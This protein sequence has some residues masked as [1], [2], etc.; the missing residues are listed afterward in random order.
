MER[1]N[2]GKYIA[3]RIFLMVPIVLGVATLSFV[4]MQLAPGDPAAAY[5]G[6]KAT[7]EAVA[8]LY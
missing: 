5:L 1:A 3:R 4:L 2:V 8:Q 6:D 7:P